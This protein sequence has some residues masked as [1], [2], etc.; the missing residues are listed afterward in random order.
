[1]LTFLTLANVL[2]D[3]GVRIKEGKFICP[4]SMKING[5]TLEEIENTEALI[6]MTNTNL[7]LSIMINK[8]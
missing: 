3:L 6:M 1:M 7:L 5:K 8:G 4:D 2:K